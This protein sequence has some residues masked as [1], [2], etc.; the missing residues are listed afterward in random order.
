M[1]GSRQ[2]QTVALLRGWF[3]RYGIA[4]RQIADGCN[5]GS[6]RLDRSAAQQGIAPTARSVF[7]AQSDGKGAGSGIGSQR[8][9]CIGC[10][11]QALLCQLEARR[12]P[13]AWV[14]T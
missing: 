3:R 5:H 12:T 9:G 4:C 14:V 2:T 10:G 13:L 7:E 8:A 11:R 1:E 6:C